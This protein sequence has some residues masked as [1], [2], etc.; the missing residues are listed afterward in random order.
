MK[1]IALKIV[2]IVAGLL[3]LMAVITGSRVLAGAFDPG[4]VTHVWLISYNV[5]MGIVSL[6]AGVLIWKE[7]ENALVLAGII[8]AAHI[9]VL[10]LLGTVFVSDVAHQSIMAMI[11]RSVVWVVLF[12]VSK[13]QFGKL[14]L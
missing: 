8:T 5:F 3:G 2:A 10:L 14:H 7:N 11:F 13:R 6:V 4:Y 1:N 9:T 12:L